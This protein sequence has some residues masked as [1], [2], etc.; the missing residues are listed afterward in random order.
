MKHLKTLVSLL[1]V[2]CM[3]FCLFAC[4]SD[5]LT[6]SN[7]EDKSESKA[8]VSENASSVAESKTES[9]TEEESKIENTF[10]VMVV[11]QNGDAV[12]NV[13]IQI[14]KDS[15]IPMK[16]NTEG[17]AVFPLEITDGYK[18]SVLSCPAGYEYTGEAEIYLN[19]GIKEFTLEITK[20]GN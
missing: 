13:M 12:E 18:L 1:L 20:T 2:I 19:S 5:S 8:S 16:S 14:C 7:S 10:T 17:F 11:D 6:S 4:E 15:C 3:A 9:K